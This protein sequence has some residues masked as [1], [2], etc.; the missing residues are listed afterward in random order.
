MCSARNEWLY[1]AR[2]STQP[3]PGAAL[4]RP[5]S[6]AALIELI[7]PIQPIALANPNRTTPTF[8]LRPGHQPVHSATDNLRL[9]T[10]MLGGEFKAIPL[11]LPHLYRVPIRAIGSDQN[12]F[13]VQYRAVV[14]RVRARLAVEQVVQVVSLHGDRTQNSLDCH[15][16]RIIHRDGE[17]YLVSAY[18]EQRL[19]GAP[20]LDSTGTLIGVVSSVPYKEGA[21]SAFYLASL[22]DL[23]CC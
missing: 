5:I 22:N 1:L 3:M 15:W 4:G 8:Q 21:H 13:E 2:Y 17:H 18:S 9:E 14:P 16:G 23:E 11:N 12:A 6:D 7:A 19:I 20:V 10:S